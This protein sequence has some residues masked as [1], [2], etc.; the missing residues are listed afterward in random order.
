MADRRLPLRSGAGRAAA[1]G[2]PFR[3]GP[4]PPLAANKEAPRGNA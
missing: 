3:S 2:H 4:R 1:S